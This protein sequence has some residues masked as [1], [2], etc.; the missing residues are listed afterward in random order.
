MYQANKTNTSEVY[1]GKIYIDKIDLEYAVFNSFN[2]ELLKIAPCKFYGSDLGETG[3]ICIAAH[4]YNNDRF[5][6]RINELEIN[7]KIR[8]VNLNGDEFE[9]IVYDIFE[10]EENDTSIL[11]VHK[12]YELTLL[13]C[14]NANKKRIIVKAYIK[15]YWK[16]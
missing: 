3:N 5:F 16:N 15:E 10:T 7:D 14:N 13:T 9:Y 2:E 8:L 6:S 4:N 1:L 12:N 11:K